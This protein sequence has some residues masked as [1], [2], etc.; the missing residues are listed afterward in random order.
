MQPTVQPSGPDGE[1]RRWMRMAEDEAGR[2]EA[3]EVRAKPLDTD[4]RRMR[5]ANTEQ[6][7]MILQLQTEGTRLQT[8]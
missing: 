5:V 8:L 7:E 3:A 1:V 6:E 4:I 2:A